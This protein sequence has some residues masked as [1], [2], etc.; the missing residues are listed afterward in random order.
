MFPKRSTKH[1]KED[2]AAFAT[3]G[4]GEI[5]GF[6]ATKGAEAA[7]KM[8]ADGRCMVKATSWS[9]FDT[10]ST[11][12]DDASKNVVMALGAG[13]EAGS[14]IKAR[15]TKLVQV[16]QSSID[17]LK[18]FRSACSPRPLCLDFSVCDNEQ[19]RRCWEKAAALVKMRQ[20]EDD[21]ILKQYDAEGFAYWEVEIRDE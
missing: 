15:K 11:D 21:Q 13:K 4:F 7:R 14:G 20:D 8:A 19:M 6:G 12:R 16:K 9:D 18:E 10:F 17:S 5:G 1:V 2:S 3:G